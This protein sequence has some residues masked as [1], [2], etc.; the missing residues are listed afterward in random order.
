MADFPKS[1]AALALWLR[2]A[3]HGE[4]ADDQDKYLRG[5]HEQCEEVRLAV[6]MRAGNCGDLSRAER[7]ALA[8]IETNPTSAPARFLLAKIMYHS[9]LR[10]LGPDARVLNDVARDRLQ[11]S[12]KHLD[13]VI[14]YADAKRDKFWRAECFLARANV[15]HALDESTQAERDFA[16]AARLV[17]G[18]AAVEF[19]YGRFLWA[20]ERYQEAI[21]HLENALKGNA[22]ANVKFFLALCLR[23]R[24]AQGDAARATTLLVDVAQDHDCD[25]AAQALPIAVSGMTAQGR[26]SDARNLVSTTCASEGSLLIKLVLIGTIGVAEGDVEAAS[27]HALAALKAWTAK[28]DLHLTQ[29]LVDVFAKLNRYVDALPLCE[30]LFGVTGDPRDAHNVI[31]CAYAARRDD[32]IL[33]TCRRMRESNHLPRGMASLEVD[34]LQRYD[35]AEAV[36]VLRDLVRAYPDDRHAHLVLAVCRFRLRQQDALSV[37]LDLLPLPEDL[38]P[39]SGVHVVRLLRESHR[40]ADAVRYGYALVRHHY[41]HQEAHRAFC[42]AMLPADEEMHDKEILTFDSVQVGAAVCYGVSSE[43]AEN[44]CIITDD[45]NPMIRLDE[46]APDHAWGCELVGKKVG[47]LFNV[48]GTGVIP[49]TGTIKNIANKYV[50]RYQDSMRRMAIDFGKETG[51]VMGHFDAD[52]NLKPEEALRPLLAQLDAVHADTVVTEELYRDHV[53]SIHQFAK[54][55]NRSDYEGYQILLESE[56][57]VRCSANDRAQEADLQSWI[58]EAGTVVVDLTA[59]LRFIC[60]SSSIC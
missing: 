41:D 50:F 20:Q 45:A 32:L 5:V 52:K 4:S 16:E 48:P 18:D 60:W 36:R 59:I 11:V 13:E 12:A 15:L 19:D 3:P 10:D 9:A 25:F 35:V 23:Q 44:W 31:A 6:A 47:D 8:V 51:W 21:G 37:S 55:R 33:T 24:S 22:H 56:L 7:L 40:A 43:A 42:S 30:H 17:Q 58:G 53:M 14:S 46:Y 54:M 2:T 28:A 38:D 27:A 34:L 57:S 1:G 29:R 39:N 26:F 49:Q